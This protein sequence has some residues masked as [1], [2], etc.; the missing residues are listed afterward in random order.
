MSLAITDTNLARFKAWMLGR[1]RGEDTVRIYSSH[2]RSSAADPK[3]LT[4]RLV[5]R[6]APKTKRTNLAALAAWAKFSKDD[7]LR[8]QLD[9]INLP[10]SRR[11]TTKLP[12]EVAHWKKL[13]I[14][15]RTAKMPMRDHA[16]RQVLGI[17][18]IRGLR[19]S[20]ALRIRKRDITSALASGKLM[21]EGKRGKRTEFAAAPMRPE[22]EALAAIP[23]TWD[24]VREVVCPDSDSPARAAATRVWRR[25]K[26]EAAKLDIDGVYPHQLR[27]TYATNFL[28][29][30]QG[31]PRAIIKLQQHMDWESLATAASYADAVDV[32]ELDKVG[33]KMLDDLLR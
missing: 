18:A 32:G 7:D 24:Y 20:D 14:H 8:E 23:G 28:E 27:R 2:L 13:I 29:M 5:G 1:G 16:L 17:I 3:G 21:F 25:M 30:L 15:I 10:P 12:L 26:S 11:V 22:L 9:E 4:G 33:D 19:C 31:D 6:N